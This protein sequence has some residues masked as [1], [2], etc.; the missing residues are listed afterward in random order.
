MKKRMVIAFF[1][2]FM[3]GRGVLRRRLAVDGTAALSIGPSHGRRLDGHQFWS[4]RRLRL[5]TGSSNTVFGGGTQNASLGGFIVQQGTA[6]NGNR[7]F[8]RDGARWYEPVQLKQS[9]RRHCWRSSGFQL[10]S[11]NGRLRS[12]A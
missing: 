1:C 2:H 8:R 10:A 5:G 7:G 9:A 4:Q 3:D 11:R 12:R 6:D